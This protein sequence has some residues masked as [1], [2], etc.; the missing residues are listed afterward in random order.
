MLALRRRFDRS[1]QALRAA[2]PSPACR[3]QL[4]VC[5]MCSHHDPSKAKQCRELAADEV[6][7]PTL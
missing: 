7:R 4:H 5:Q 1:A 3:A 6:S 2:C